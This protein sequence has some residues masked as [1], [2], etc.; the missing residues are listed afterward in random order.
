MRGQP[1]TAEALKPAAPVKEA[2]TVKEKVGVF[3]KILRADDKANEV[4]EKHAGKIAIAGTIAL[5]GGVAFEIS[6]LGF[7][8]LQQIYGWQGLGS[9]ISMQ[10]GIGV[11]AILGGAGLLVVGGE[12]LWERHVEPILEAVGSYF[13]RGVNAAMDWVKGLF[14]GKK[15]ENPQNQ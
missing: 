15:K 10:A 3:G 6:A 13:D 14:G 4:Q 12:K 1:G 5:G 9:V 11:L 8:V 2:E 7:Y